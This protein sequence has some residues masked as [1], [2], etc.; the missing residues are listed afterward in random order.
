MRSRPHAALGRGSGTGA[1]AGE[2]GPSAPR[3]PQAVLARWRRDR[4]AFRR[5]AIVL[6]D[7]RLFGDVIED[8]QESETLVPSTTPLHRHAYLER[9]RGH[10]KTGD[11]GTLGRHGVG[12]W[13]RR[14]R[15]TRRRRPTRTKRGLL[16][17]DVRGKFMRSPLLGAAE[18]KLTRTTLTVTA[19][20]STLT[21]LAGRCPL[22][23]RAP[24]RHDRRGRTE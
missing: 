2:A 18:S 3:D 12:G 4:M 10:S 1:G 19:T 11:L 15:R 20:G 14:A 8:W 5:E 7:G 13:A 22:G 16:L 21:V 6:E 23:L 9:P 17:D 24:A